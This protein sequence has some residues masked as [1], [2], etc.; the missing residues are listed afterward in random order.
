MV[1]SVHIDIG[2]G[3]RYL[4]VFFEFLSISKREDFYNIIR[5]LIVSN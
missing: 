2:E 4:Y 3:P 5:P 1:L